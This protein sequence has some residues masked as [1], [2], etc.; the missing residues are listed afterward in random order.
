M[1]EPRTFFEEKLITLNARVD[2]LARTV[3][4]LS[5]VRFTLF[6]LFLILFVYF[7]N[8]R[9]YTAMTFV[10][11]SFPVVFGVLVREFNKR[12]GLLRFLQDVRTICMAELNRLDLKLHDLDGGSEF[13]DR[14]HYYSYDLDLF[15]DHSLFQLINRTSTPDARKMISSWMLEPAQPEEIMQRQEAVAELAEKPEW[16]IDFLAHGIS[17]KSSADQAG[18]L[19]Q[20]LDED[21]SGKIGMVRTIYSFLSPVLF[22]TGLLGIIFAGW[23]V[24]VL[25]PVLLVNAVILLRNQDR[26]KKL[27]EQT[28]GNVRLLRSYEAMIHQLAAAQFRSERICNLQEPFLHGARKS[29]SSLRSLLD[30]MDGR[31][32]MFYSLFNLVFLLDIHL[33]RSIT[34]WKQSNREDLTRWF[35]NLSQV[36]VLCSLGAHSF[37]HPEYVFPRIGRSWKLEAKEI[38]HPLIPASECITNDFSMDGEGTVVIIT[39]SNMSG[40]STFLRT[41]GINVVLG[42]MGAPVYAADMLIPVVRLFTGM[43][44]EDDLSSHISSFYAELRRI[45]YLLDTIEEASVPVLFMLDEIL[46]G[47]NTRDRHR[48]SEGLVKQLSEMKAFGFI[49][50]HDLGI[51]ELAGQDESIRNYSFNSRIEGD[52]ILFDYKISKGICH[53][54]NASKLMEKM[55]IQLGS[56]TGA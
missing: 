48:G 13:S 30:Y 38:G 43:R 37:L 56:D 44:S 12:S 28:D 15:G 35:Q 34:R 2:V 40:K 31:G 53:S 17:A 3:L 49:S 52:E 29:I 51:G 22:I 1:T 20:W 26:I 54:F 16:I 39:G 32:N 27:G 55:G 14:S 46:R 11:V 9:N 41:V 19:K 47:T 25:A 33:I 24:Y 45:R 5:W 23:S 7:A 6:L 50:T 42:L 36:E 10:A 21:E 4:R 8:A 18:R